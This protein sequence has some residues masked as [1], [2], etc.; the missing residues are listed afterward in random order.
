MEQVTVD[1]A[2]AGWEPLG[3]S[4]E[5]APWSLPAG[6]EEPGYLSTKSRVARAAPLKGW[7]AA[8]LRF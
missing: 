7:G 1:G 3:A 2:Q 5:R 8:S 4:M 6:A